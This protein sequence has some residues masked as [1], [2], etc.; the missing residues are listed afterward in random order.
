M[1]SRKTPRCGCFTSMGEMW[2]LHVVTSCFSNQLVAAS[3][4]KKIT[5]NTFHRL[6]GKAPCLPS[7]SLRQQAR[8]LQQQL[9][10]PVG[11]ELTIKLSQQRHPETLLSMSSAAGADRILQGFGGWHYLLFRALPPPA[12]L[13]LILL[14]LFQACWLRP[15]SP[16]C[17]PC[18]RSHPFCTSLD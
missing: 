7:V 10:G 11:Q 14:T 8:C 1:G 3:P 2:A 9:W 15:Q 4:R 16:N 5:R 18:P 6:L 13:Q 17:S 12:S